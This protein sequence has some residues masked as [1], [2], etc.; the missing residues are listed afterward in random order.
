MTVISVRGTVSCHI[1]QQTGQG[2]WSIKIAGSTAPTVRALGNAPTTRAMSRG[3][4]GMCGKSIWRWWMISAI[5]TGT[6]KSTQIIERIF[7]TAKEQHGSRYTQYIGRA[8]MEMKVGLTFACMN[9]KRLA[10][11]LARKGR[12]GLSF[13]EHLCTLKRIYLKTRERCWSLAPAP[14]FVYSLRTTPPV[15]PFPILRSH[16]RTDRPAISC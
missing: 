10:R 16:P 15:V 2:I 14:L 1:V 7:G 9:L 6:G 12:G 4:P 5:P 3:L 8:R 13:Q 11:I